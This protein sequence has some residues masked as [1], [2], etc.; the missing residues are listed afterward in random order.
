MLISLIGNNA[1][2]QIMHHEFTHGGLQQQLAP[3]LVVMLTIWLLLIAATVI[4][5]IRAYC[6]THILGK[7]PSMQTSRSRFL[8][9]VALVRNI[10]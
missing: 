6:P 8:R 9:S 4:V 3:F 7:R 5:E 2:L 10:K 1:I